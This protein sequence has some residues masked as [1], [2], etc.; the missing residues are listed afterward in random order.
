MQNEFDQKNG[1]RRTT[2]S[3]AVTHKLVLSSSQNNIPNPPGMQSPLPLGRTDQKKPRI[4]KATT[5]LTLLSQ[6]SVN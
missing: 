6:P 1:I 5:L 2:C 3:L 4:P